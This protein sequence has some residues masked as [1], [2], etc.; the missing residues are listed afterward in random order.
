MCQNTSTNPLLLYFKILHYHL[1]F[2]D[3][4][5][6]VDIAKLNC[7]QEV[8]DVL[9][10]IQVNTH[11]VA[12]Q[13]QVHHAII[14]YYLHCK[15]PTICIIQQHLP[16]SKEVIWLFKYTVSRVK[17]SYGD[18]LAVQLHRGMNTYHIDL[19]SDLFADMRHSRSACFT[20]SSLWISTDI[21]D[22]IVKCIAVCAR[23]LTLIYGGDT[24]ALVHIMVDLILKC[25]TVCART[26]TL[27]YGGD[28]QALVHI[29]VDLILEC[30]V[31]SVRPL[32]L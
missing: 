3:I 21:S 26:L 4:G 1:N 15:E 7:K 10:Q 30:K 5:S 29:M 24:Q 6:L 12:N 14:R 13:A 22:L 17:R 32:K 20:L 19:W 9:Y 27:I 18:S 31:V 16:Y 8:L 23:T 11:T 25:M 2:T 28:T